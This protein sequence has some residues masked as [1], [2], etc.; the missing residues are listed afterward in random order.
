MIHIQE[1]D[2]QYCKTIVYMPFQAPR[3]TD[4]I[5]KNGQN[6]VHPIHNPL[7]IVCSFLSLFDHL[8]FLHKV[9]YVD[10]VNI[11]FS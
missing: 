2:S 10:S 3:K 9:Q 8:W 4:Q 6:V 11:E 5:E 1:D 7:K